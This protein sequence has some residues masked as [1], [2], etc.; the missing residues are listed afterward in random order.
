VTA[1]GGVEGLVGQATVLGQEN[2]TFPDP[3]LLDLTSTLWTCSAP[4]SL[5]LGGH[6]ELPGAQ[7]EVGNNVGSMAIQPFLNLWEEEGR[8]W[9]GQSL[10]GTN[11]GHCTT[12]RH[13]H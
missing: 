2:F 11:Q 4:P 13:T 9:R 6:F 3:A 12:P 1:Q 7:A 8:R 10:P 5:T